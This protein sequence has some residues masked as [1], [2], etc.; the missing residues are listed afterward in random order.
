MKCQTTCVGGSLEAGLIY[1]YLCI[2]PS[3]PLEV[4]K[5]KY[6]LMKRSVFPPLQDSKSQNFQEFVKNFK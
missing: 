6:L 4:E 1:S 3:S 2:N 5:I